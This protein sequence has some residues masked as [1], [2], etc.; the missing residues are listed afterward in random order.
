[1]KMKNERYPA[2]S[3]SGEMIYRAPG[4]FT[5]K[6][7]P[8][9]KVLM[10]AFLLMSLQDVQG[11]MRERLV[12]D[13][14][15][16][17][18]KGGEAVLV[19]KDTLFNGNNAIDYH[20]KGRTTGIT[21]KLFKVDD[22][23]ES[24]VDARTYLPYRAVRNIKERKYRYYNEVFFNQ[25]VDSIYSKKTGQIKVPHNLTDILSVFFYFVRQGMIHD[26]DEGKSI[27]IPTINGHDIKQI[28]I[29][30]DGFEDIQT[31]M[32]PVT[33]YVLSPVMEKGKVLT[34]SDGL[35]FYISKDKK[36]PIQLDF[37]TKA[38]TL[39]AELV[40]YKISGKEQ[41]R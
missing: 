33:C 11:K 34:R 15:L 16:G 39:R 4:R 2:D 31:K 37:D 35:K 12:F 20:L 28:K 19:I 8:V 40:S 1:M 23:Y 7:L 30:F 6:S 32:G 5:V 38:G 21:D 36:I 41:F 24:T 18:V 10:V 14:K 17:F 29:R 9:L 22:V 27:V 26:I 3:V 13:L 25:A